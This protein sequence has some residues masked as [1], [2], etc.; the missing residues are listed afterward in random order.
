MKAYE[1]QH[2]VGFE[3]TNLVGNAYY[4]SHL[5]WQG[6]A[7]EMFL[8][9]YFPEIL[10]ELENGLAL[11]T[12]HCSCQYLGELN[13]FDQ[14]I[15][16]MFLNS[17][18]QNRIAMRFEYWRQGPGEE[19]VARGDQEIA[20]MRREGTKLVPIAIPLKLLNALEAFSASCCGVHE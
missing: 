19:L 9:E 16:R 7:R 10:T 6:R 4:V 3:E 18:A 13:A 8:R 20:C 14:V 17:V 5:R 1:Y 12:L 11:I 15:V 2:V